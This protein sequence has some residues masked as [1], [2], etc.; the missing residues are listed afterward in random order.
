MARTRATAVSA[1]V[2]ALGL[3]AVGATPFIVQSASASVLLD[4]VEPCDP[5]VTLCGDVTPETTITVTVT[6][7]SPTPTTP[8]EAPE[9]TVT[10]TVTASPPKASKTPKAPKPS[11]TTSAPAPTPTLTQTP[12]P[13][14]PQPLPTQS[15]EVPPVTS[16]TPTPEQSVEMPAIAPS[17]TP[18]ANTL[19]S[20]TQVASSEEVPLELRRAAPE[21][22]QTELTRKLSIP[23]LVLVLLALFAVLIFEGRLRRM[24][25]AAAVRKAGPQAMTT[26][27]TSPM[28]GP[29]PY[30]AG[31]GYPA[32]PGYAATAGGF[33]APA[34]SYPGGTA[35]APII[36]FVP[37]QTYPSGPPQYGY[38][39]P[40]P[41]PP[42]G[43]TQEPP[44]AEPEP[45]VLHPDEFDSYS[46]PP[47]PRERDLF[48]PLVP[49]AP[50]P[51]DIPPGG[52]APFDG[53][54]DQPLGPASAAEAGDSEP[55]GQERPGSL[56]QPARD[57]TPGDTYEPPAGDGYEP[58]PY[59]PSDDREPPSGRALGDDYEP[60]PYLAPD[61]DV[62]AVQPLPPPPAPQEPTKEMPDET[63]RRFGRRKKK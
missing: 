9:T 41:Y 35:Y 1:I 53:G 10:K 24:A 29:D 50:V 25:H 63:R 44:P 38:Q 47:K 55:W 37:V 17:D 20:E 31:G 51:Q 60:P 59:R 4:P 27:M 58:P 39:E 33:P 22:D 54:V 26:P 13:Q 28:P 30:A 56:F 52:A 3:T 34:P 61:A 62:T 8:D 11:K 45:V 42:Q 43:Y 19:P 32:G 23:A 18:T 16:T 46:E 7:G 21:F 15:V 57:R 6:D 49:P 5:D 14:N 40:H 2:L 12:P 36:S 48:E